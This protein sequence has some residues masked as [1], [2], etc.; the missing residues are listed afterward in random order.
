MKNKNKIYFTQKIPN[1]GYN[2]S[3]TLKYRTNSNNLMLYLNR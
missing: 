2:K 1:K 3:I